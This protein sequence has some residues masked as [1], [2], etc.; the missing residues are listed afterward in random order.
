MPGARRRGRPRTA[1]IDNIKSWTG[2]HLWKSQSEWQRIEINGES[3]SMVWPTLGSR[4]AK[5]QN[6]YIEL[7]L[8]NFWCQYSKKNLACREQTLGLHF[9]ILIT[10]QCNK[11]FLSLQNV[12]LIHQVNILPGFMTGV[13][14]GWTCVGESG[15][16]A[17]SCWYRW[18]PRRLIVLSFDE[19]TTDYRRHIRQSISR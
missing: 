4:K 19:F 2:L 11:L 8:V 9:K 14:A 12:L 1:W 13:A 16:N 5:E 3:T 17:E 7:V 15:S 6:R 10:V 18:Q